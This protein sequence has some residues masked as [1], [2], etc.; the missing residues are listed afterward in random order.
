MPALRERA[1]DIPLL[2]AHFLAALSESVGKRISGFSPAALAAMAGYAWP[3]NIRELHNCIERALIV[4]KTAL[5]DVQDL[6]RDLFEG[7]RRAGRDGLPHDLDAEL[8]RIEREF[9]LEALRRSDGVQVKAARMLGI[10]ERSLWHRIKKLD[11]RLN[12]TVAD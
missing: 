10:A 5:I 6:P 12:R 1:E 11:I 8:E 3:G 4:A 2:A 9:I 7:Q